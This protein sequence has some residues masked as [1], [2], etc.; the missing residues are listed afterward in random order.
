MRT[1]CNTQSGQSVLMTYDRAVLS[2]TGAQQKVVFHNLYLREMTIYTVKLRDD[3][4]YVIHFS[5]DMMNREL[6]LE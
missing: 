5:A 1:I 3:F 6:V 4:S 2:L